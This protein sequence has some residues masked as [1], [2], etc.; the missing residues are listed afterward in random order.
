[1]SPS[2]KPDG[3]APTGSA[4][5]PF[6]ETRTLERA[7]FFALLLVGTV[8][9]I[10]GVF[11]SWSALSF[12]LRS[13]VAEAHVVGTQTAFDSPGAATSRRAASYYPRLEFRDSSG[14]AHEFVGDVSRKDSS[15]R[16]GWPIGSTVRI[17]Y[18]K[19]NPDNARMGGT[20]SLL[21]HLFLLLGLGA[22]ALAFKVRR[23][24]QAGRD[25]T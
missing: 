2:T 17:R 23:G 6:D 1:M 14:A 22:M 13:E 20:W 16:P 8:F 4:A 12:R 11:V 5:V 25:G 18:E 9:T 24:M 19:A 7:P 15:G 10:V 21:R 3:G